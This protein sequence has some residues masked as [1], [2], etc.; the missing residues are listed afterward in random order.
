MS[1]ASAR[2]RRGWRFWHHDA[3][4]LLQSPFG[5][6]RGRHES[7]PVW[8][9]S[10]FDAQCRHGCAAIPGP[11]CHC[12]IHFVHD[13]KALAAQLLTNAMSYPDRF[14]APCALG[15]IDAWGTV[16]PAE[17]D[18]TFGTQPVWRTGS[19]VIRSLVIDDR[20]RHLT[21]L[22]EAVYQVPV[23]GGLHGGARGYGRFW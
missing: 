19:A 20:M 2:C 3:A 16:V 5:S 15:L 18:Q 17:H 13:G 4:G 14:S 9:S 8:G 12:G 1:A 21:P 23:R 6:N 10:R 11:G 7:N 22:L